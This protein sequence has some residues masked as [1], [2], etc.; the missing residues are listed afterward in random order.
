MQ[1]ILIP[2]LSVHSKESQS[3]VGEE[4]PPE[5]DGKK[6]NS[7]SNEPPPPKTAWAET[8]QP[9]ET[10]PGPPAPKPPQPPLHR[11]PAGN[12]STPGDYPVSVYN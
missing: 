3:A 6:D 1:L 4:Q 12:W 8:S 11:G 9:P 10:E 2:L 7:P 5:A